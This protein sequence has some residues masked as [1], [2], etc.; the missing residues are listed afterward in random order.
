MGVNENLMRALEIMFGCSPWTYW[1]VMQH[2]KDL[3]KISSL[4]F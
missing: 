3:E 4:A 2:L 1:I